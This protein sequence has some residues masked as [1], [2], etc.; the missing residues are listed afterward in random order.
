[1]RVVSGRSV[2]ASVAAIA[3]SLPE[4]QR[5][6]AELVVRDPE[7]V[8]FG[9][10]G[11]VA[12][13]TGTSNP[14]V[15]RFASR[16]GF[17]GFIALRD[18]VRDEVSQQI[19]SA[20]GRVNQPSSGPLLERALAVELANVE[21]TL[22]AVDDQRLAQATDLLTDLDRRLWVLPSSQMQ[23]VAGHLADDLQLC[24][25]RVVLLTG[26]EFRIATALARLRAGDVV[27][28]LDTQRHERWLVRVQRSA[29][30]RGGVPLVVTD[31]LPCSLDL[32]G[33]LALTFACDT[34]SPFESQV[35]LLAL[36]NL[37]VSATVERLRPT[38][39]DRVERLEQTWVEDDLFDV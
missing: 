1:V 26:S 9:T 23:G 10:V 3:G 24:R 39:A 33:G 7:A 35:G 14:T 25:P 27:L 21:R 32:T 6:V 36:A 38:V 16:L 34:T 15:I 22:G 8:A 20:I 19:R 31:R 11:S 30:H 37:L 5:R 12:Q 18:A 2:Q 13:K 4:S 29:V 28:S 17:D